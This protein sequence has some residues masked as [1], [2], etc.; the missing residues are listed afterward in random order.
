MIPDIIE[1]P[2]AARLLQLVSPSFTMLYPHLHH[3]QLIPDNV[4]RAMEASWNIGYFSERAVT[5]SLLKDVYV[6]QEGLVFDAAGRLFK[7][8]ITQHAGPEIERGYAAVQAAIGADAVPSL[9]AVSVL[10]KKRGVGNFGHWLMEMLPK[11]YLAKLHLGIGALRYIVPAAHGG[12]R[13]VIT[14]SL[15]MLMIHEAELQPIGDEV[16][17]F[18]SLVLVEGLTQHGTYMSPLVLNC[19]ENLAAS[20]RGAG[21][22]R[23][24]V[25]RSGIA[26]R[27]FVNEA[28][29]EQLAKA[30]GYRLIEPGGMSFVEQIATFKN[31]MEIIGVMGAA[32]TN[33]AFASGGARV[34]SIAPANMPDT[35]FWFISGLRGQHYT[36]LRCAQTGPIRGVASWDTDL[37][38]DAND[39]PHLFAAA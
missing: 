8:S 11:A 33:I 23:L 26:S 6:A 10:C 24:F 34:V 1:T 16:W 3:R 19:M 36:E 21:F 14:D 29:I 25:T 9:G 28:E 12:L 31:A 37:V 7:G 17:H 30:R 27:R 39:L 20:V 18:D 22:E 2:S 4:L 15:A 5:F 38:L 35:F 13:Q 32:M